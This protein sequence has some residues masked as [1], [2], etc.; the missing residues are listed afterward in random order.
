MRGDD[1]GSPFELPTGFERCAS[2]DGETVEVIRI[3]VDLLAPEQAL[4]VDEVQGHPIQ[5]GRIQAAELGAPVRRHLERRYRVG[6]RCEILFQRCVARQDQPH[7]VPQRPQGLR[8]A[9]GYVR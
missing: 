2:E 5:F 6:E 3:A 4:V 9:G 8:Q 1:V 7:V